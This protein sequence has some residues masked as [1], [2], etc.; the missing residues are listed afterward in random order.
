MNIIDQGFEEALVMLSMFESETRLL[1][2]LPV[3]LE[4]TN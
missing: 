1:A 4:V 2:G 3:N